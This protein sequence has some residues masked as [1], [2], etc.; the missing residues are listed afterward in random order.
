MERPAWVPW[1]TFHG[2]EEGGQQ[3]P[4]AASD[5]GVCPAAESCLSQGH[6]LPGA[7]HIWRLSKKGTSV[8][9]RT[10]PGGDTYS[11]APWRLA[12]A[13]PGS[14]HSPALPSAQR[15]FRP[16]PSR[17]RVLN[18][19]G[20]PRPIAA[21]ALEP[22]P[23]PQCCGPRSLLP[24]ASPGWGDSRAPLPQEHPYRGSAKCWGR[25][26]QAPAREGG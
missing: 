22:H 21:A 18:N 3:R 2:C 26:E 1:R 5:F 15:C 16:F 19:H 24:G 20:A 7:A 12:E 23:S 25:T 4:P 11:R 6:T 10:T 14:P 8:P 17:L 9:G 13:G